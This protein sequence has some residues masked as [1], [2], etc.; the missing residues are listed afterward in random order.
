MLRVSSVVG[1][2]ALA[3]FAPNALS[4]TC[5]NTINPY[6]ANNSG[7]VGGAVYFDVAVTGGVLLQ[8]I[9]S[10]CQATLGTPCGI[11]VYTIPGTSVGNQTN[12]GLWTLVG[13]DNGTTTS[14]G[15]NGV[16]RFTL[17]SPIV[18][19]AGTYGMAL[20]ARGTGHAYTN[21]TG[22]NQN[23]SD[24]FLNIT[25]G[26]ASNVPWTGIIN[27]RVWN[28]ALCYVPAAGIYPN[29]TATPRSGNIPLN[30]QF[31]DTTYTSDPAGVQTW[32]WDLDGDG[33]NE[34]FTQNPT[35]TYSTEGRY[36]IC[37]LY[38]SRCV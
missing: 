6:L 14:A 7:S 17:Q 33:I 8:A 22:A 38:T 34:T 31:T 35:I 3:A 18:L 24:S 20:V 2:L 23:Y 21:G 16:T 4:Q 30:V 32:A 36:N 29:F 13:T 10:N 1:A 5:L 15:R 28:G 12:P 9:E 11:D 19:T 37:L 25:L 27:P 26:Q